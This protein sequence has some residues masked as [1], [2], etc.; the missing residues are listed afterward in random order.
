M[1]LSAF[2]IFYTTVAQPKDT[3]TVTVASIEKMMDYQTGQIKLLSGNA[4]LRVPKGFKFINAKNAQYVLHDLWGNPEDTTVQGAILPEDATVTAAGCW[5]FTVTFDG[6]GFV[7]DD[8]AK[9]V[10][11]DD[12]L[13]EMKTDISNANPEREKAGYGKIELVGWASKPFYDANKKVLHWA[14]ELKFNNDTINTLNYDLRI[15]GRKGVFVLSA[16]GSIN[17][18]SE[19]KP[20]IDQIISSI[21]FNEGEKYA[22]FDS[23]TDEVAAW[24]IGGLVA[25]KVL[26]K[27]GFFAILAKFG[28][29]IFV[30]LIAAFAA[31]KKFIFGKKD[32][33]VSKPEIA[34]KE[35]E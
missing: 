18:L 1:F 7:K 32:Q 20:N 9:D 27:V 23:S 19:I 8:D 30:A 2:F 29:V 11:Y 14:K 3:A 4:T 28:K 31:I 25:G 12:L 15:L 10:N 35:V 24:T 17:Q 5:L 6:M 22:N 16:V 26:A 21:E 34:S 13:A 33:E